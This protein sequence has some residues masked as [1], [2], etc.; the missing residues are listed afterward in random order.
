MGISSARAAPNRKLFRKE[1]RTMKV[2][3]QSCVGALVAIGLVAGG[4]EV[5]ERVRKDDSDKKSKSPE[6]AAA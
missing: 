1:E 4:R 6:Q 3:L 5:Y 2:I